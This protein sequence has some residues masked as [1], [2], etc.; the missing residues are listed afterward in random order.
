MI[1][2]TA[3]ALI[4]LSAVCVGGVSGAD[5]VS[6]WDGTSKYTWAGL[7]TASDP[8]LITSAAELAGLADQVNK[9]NTYQGY[10]FK[11]TTDIDLNKR[12]WTPIGT[13]NNMKNGEAFSGVFDGGNHIISNMLQSRKTKG[14]NRGI[15]HQYERGC[16]LVC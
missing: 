10:Y 2:L 6:V 15:A 13:T 3:F 4:L 12:E 11:L 14:T 7:G 5:E 8:Y 9:R 1:L 16:A